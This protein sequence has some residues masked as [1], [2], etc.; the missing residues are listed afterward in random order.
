MG[1][2][3]LGRWK[4]CGLRYHGCCQMRKVSVCLDPSIGVFGVVPQVHGY[5]GEHGIGCFQGFFH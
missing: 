5:W 4:G 2:N 3:A 1:V